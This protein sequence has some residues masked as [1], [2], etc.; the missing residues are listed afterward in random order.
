MI[1]FILYTV[2][3]LLANAS[4]AK[5]LF[6]SIQPGQW[7]DKLLDWQDR[8]QQW[9][10]E[11]KQFL[12]KAGG[13]CELCF[14]HLI[15]FICFWGYALFMNTVTGVWISAISPNLIVTITINA[16]W[17]LVYVSLGTNLSLYFIIK[18]FKK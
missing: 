7:L 18:L 12:A 15:T 5:I 4:L 3:A 1:I 14:S 10:M 17:Y 16:I 11:G 13:Y 9:D 6:I 8:L 2:I